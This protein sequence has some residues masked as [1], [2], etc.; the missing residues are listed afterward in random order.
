MDTTDI[1][2]QLMAAIREDIR[3]FRAAV[4]QRFAAVDRRFDA[5][6]Q[7]FD[8]RFDAV[9]QRFNAVE[10]SLVALYQM[11]TV[12]LAAS[13]AHLREIN[14]AMIEMM[15]VHQRHSDAHHGIGHRLEQC[16]RDIV[17][18]KLRVP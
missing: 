11:V 14:V 6:E 13:S 2:P 9:D 5:V 16:E 18:L 8:R 1:T 12:D 10:T 15:A 7:R 3:E 17:D 4:D